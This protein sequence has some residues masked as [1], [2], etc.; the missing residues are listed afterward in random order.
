MHTVVMTD[1]EIYEYASN[2]IQSIVCDLSK[3]IYGELGGNLSFYWSDKPQVSAWAESE[4]DPYHPPQH[5]VVICYELARKLYR[6]AEDYH[7]FAAGELLEDEIQIFFQGFDPKPKLPEHLEIADSIRNMFLGSLT[8][9]FFHEVGHLMQEHGYIRS[10][11]GNNHTITPIEDCES[12]GSHLLEGREAVIAHVTEFAADVEATLWCVGEL[13]RHFLPE[14]INSEEELYEEFRSNLYLLVCGISC[15][16][17]R[18]YGQRPLMPEPIPASSH[19]TPIRRL[20]VCLPNIFEKLST[21][22]GSEEL[23]GMSRK[24]LVNLCIGAAYSAGFFWHW[25]YAQESIIPNDFMPKGLLQDKYKNEYWAAIIL[26]W[27]EVNP[28]IIKIRR[29][30]SKLGILSFTS[31]FRSKIFEQS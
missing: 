6:D 26:A 17:Y 24:Q 16:F 15:V 11:S 28:E 5:K 27:D 12:N 20:E 8:W 21:S 1:Q 3:G 25:T 7:F 31:E 22:N 29:F 23:P 14:E 2:V 13:A 4:G 9:V 19:P 30:G 10:L 18:F